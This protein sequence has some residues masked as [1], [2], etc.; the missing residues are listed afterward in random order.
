MISGVFAAAKAIP[1][2]L[3]GKLSKKIISKDLAL[4]LPNTA[5]D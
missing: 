2:I 1:L 4:K 5:P 3:A